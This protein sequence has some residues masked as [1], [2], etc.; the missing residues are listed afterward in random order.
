[1]ENPGSSFIRNIESIAAWVFP[2]PIPSARIPSLKGELHEVHLCCALQLMF[3]ALH[4]DKSNLPKSKSDDKNQLHR[5][6][7]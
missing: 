6:D 1:M 7:F 4:S 2:T 3:S 5:Q